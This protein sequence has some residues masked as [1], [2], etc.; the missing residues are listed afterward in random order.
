MIVFSA[1]RP[2]VVARWDFFPFFQKCLNIVTANESR[3]Q[4]SACIIFDLSIP[5]QI[6]GC[7]KGGGMGLGYAPRNS[8]IFQPGRLDNPSEPRRCNL[9]SWLRSKECH[10]R[11]CWNIAHSLWLRQWI[12]MECPGFYFHWEPHGMEFAR[13]TISLRPKYISF[14]DQFSPFKFIW[15]VKGQGWKVCLENCMIIMSQITST[16]HLICVLKEGVFTPGSLMVQ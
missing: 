12:R 1:Y 7:I 6:L 11:R 3:A 14:S 8:G 10:D 5:D 9:Y 4:F 15:Y 16:A 13:C 2:N